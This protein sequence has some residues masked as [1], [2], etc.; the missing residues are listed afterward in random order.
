MIA[1]EDHRYQ[2]RPDLGYV[3]MAQD[4]A[5]A[6]ASVQ[7]DFGLFT[8]QEIK[9]VGGRGRQGLRII[10]SK[11]S[12]TQNEAAIKTLSAQKEFQYVAPLFSCNGSKI[13]VIPEIVVRVTS[14]IPVDQL[15]SQCTRVGCTI[16]QPMEFTTQEYLLGVEGSNA[17]AVFKTVNELNNIAWIEWA[18]PNIAFKP[19]PCGF[20]L[21]N[22]EYFPLQWHLHNTGEFVGTPNVDINAPEAWE[23]TTGDP[24]IVVAVLDTGVDSSHPDLVNNLVPFPVSEFRRFHVFRPL[25][26]ESDDTI[27]N[28]QG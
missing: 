28:S 6:I 21:P 10:E 17:E 18:A 25:S 24:N 20:A 23:I 16:L 1:G 15:E 19:K 14:G 12:A 26:F 4:N 27:S 8:R 7:G 13:T 3:I 22:D 11:P 9:Y 2:P 5:D